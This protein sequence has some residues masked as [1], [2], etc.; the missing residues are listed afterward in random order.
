MEHKDA[1]CT[2]DGVVG[3]TYCTR[4]EYDKAAAEAEIEATGH[5]YGEV[6]WTWN[7]DHTEAVATITCAACAEGT[8]GKTLSATAT[9]EQITNVVT[10]PATRREPGVRTYTATVT[11]NGVDVTGTATA[12]IPRRTGGGGGG[13][14]TTTPTTPV[15]PPTEITEPDVPLAELPMTFDD[16]K[17]GDWFYDAVKYAYDNELMK[18]DSATK[19][20]PNNN[21]TRGMIALILYRMEK[22]PKAEGAGFPDV[23]A[24]S[25]Y[26]DAATWA[27]SVNVFKGY[28][29]GTFRGDQV[30]TR[31]ELAAV[32][33]RYAEMKQYDVTA[34]AE[35]IGFADGAAVQEWAVPAMKWA[36]AKELVGGRE[37]NVIAPQANATRAELATILT[38]FADKVVPAAA[39]KA[40]GDKTENATAEDKKAEDAKT[41]TK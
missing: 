36:V 20:A 22:E 4:C 19:F 7:A 29:D 1:N 3:G 13:S 24:N 2:E 38:R 27:V 21:T 8:E 16:V 26:K 33:F 18:G 34:A 25:W 5:T 6:V 28:E 14:S 9:G 11:L 23:A 30:I 40:D 15:T 41:E 32:M 37:G 12:E 31:E 35:L 39:D 10:T 17:E